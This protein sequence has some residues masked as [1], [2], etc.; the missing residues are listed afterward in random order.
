MEF[1]AVVILGE[2]VERRAIHNRD[3]GRTSWPAAPM[4]RRDP[5]NDVDGCEAVLRE[6][7]EDLLID[8]NLPVVEVPIGMESECNPCEEHQS[9]GEKQRWMGADADDVG[10]NYPT[11]EAESQIE[12]VQPG[13]ASLDRPDEL[14]NDLEGA[15][16]SHPAD[17]TQQERS[18]DPGQ[19]H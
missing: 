14:K 18:T 7:V 4:E 15:D 9:P 13:Y 5:S 12:K 2:G 10:R 17:H 16:P 19:D 11:T 6:H 1:G 3:G 8:G